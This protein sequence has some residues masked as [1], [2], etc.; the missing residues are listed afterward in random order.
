[1]AQKTLDKYFSVVDSQLQCCSDEGSS[2]TNTIQI[3]TSDVVVPS[4]QRK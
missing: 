2:T 3:G 4:D 1:M